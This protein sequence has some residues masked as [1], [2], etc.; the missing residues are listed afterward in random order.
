VL[1]L[2]SGSTGETSAMLI[3][4]GGA[5]LIARNM[6]NWRIPARSSAPCSR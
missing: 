1:G 6:M 4:P 2:T 3:L 5:Y